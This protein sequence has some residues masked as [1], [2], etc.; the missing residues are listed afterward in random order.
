ME[1]SREVYQNLRRKFELGLISRLELTTAD[2]NYLQAEAEYLSAMLEVLQ[3]G[4]ALDTL[5]GKILNN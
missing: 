3:A 1:V 2:S 4:N 5:S